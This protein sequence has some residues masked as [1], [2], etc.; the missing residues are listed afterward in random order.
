M[1]YQCMV[2]LNGD[3]RVITRNGYMP[4]NQPKGTSALEISTETQLHKLCGEELSIVFSIILLST[5]FSQIYVKMLQ[6]ADYNLIIT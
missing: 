4:R 2:F 1:K 5:R 6:R 3:N